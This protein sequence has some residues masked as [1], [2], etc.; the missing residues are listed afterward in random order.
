MALFCAS[1][2]LRGATDG[3]RLGGGLDSDR[4]AMDA[5]QRSPAHAFFSASTNREACDVIKAPAVSSEIEGRTVEDV[6]QGIDI[7]E[8]AGIPQG[9]P[10]PL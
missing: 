9:A 3:L 4:A 1:L 6:L 5:A 7:F 10:F 8:R 2:V